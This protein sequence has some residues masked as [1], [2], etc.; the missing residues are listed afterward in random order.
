MRRDEATEEG[1][2]RMW[3]RSMW[4]LILEF[5]LIFGCA[6]ALWCFRR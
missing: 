4:F 3:K 2:A 6:I 1:I 5:G